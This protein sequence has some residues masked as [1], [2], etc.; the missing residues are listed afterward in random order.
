MTGEKAPIVVLFRR[1]LRI[2]DNRALA[3]AADTGRAMLPLFIL[4]E[5]GPQARPAGAASRWWLHYS[6][7][8]LEAALAELGAKLILREG[9][10]ETIVAEAIKASGA[11]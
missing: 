4:D 2:A 6:L 1:D 7:A 9:V 5:N 10:T 3:A 8:A 11:D